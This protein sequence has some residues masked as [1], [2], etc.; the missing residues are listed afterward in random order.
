MHISRFS[1]NLNIQKAKTFLDGLIH[2]CVGPRPDPSI[3]TAIEYVR[4]RVR[5]IVRPVG[6]ICSGEDASQSAAVVDSSEDDSSSDSD[7]DVASPAPFVPIRSNRDLIPEWVMD[8][9][10]ERLRD[11]GRFCFFVLVYTYSCG[12]NWLVS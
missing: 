6:V 3:V 11:S 2:L 12:F 4:P 7:E 10:A 1:G 5:G 9:L 8:V